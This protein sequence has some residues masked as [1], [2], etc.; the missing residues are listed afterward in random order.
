M[1]IA[2]VGAQ[3][4][5]WT[6]EQKSKAK[7]KIKEIIMNH[8]IEYDN[9]GQFEPELRPIIVSGHCPV[10][11]E[12]WYCV[13]CNGWGDLVKDTQLNPDCEYHKGMVISIYDLGGV[14]SWVEIIAARY[15]LKKEIYPAEVNQ[16]NNNSDKCPN[17][18]HV[19][20]LPRWKEVCEDNRPSRG[21][22]SR[23]IQIAEACDILYDIEPAGK[24]RY[25]NGSGSRKRYHNG[26]YGIITCK[27]CNGDGSYSGGTWTLKYAK[28]LGKIVNKIIIN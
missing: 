23:N 12:R 16:W 27:Y 6:E 8:Y 20:Y 24:C 26:G 21:Y 28:K 2:I 17:C 15:K 7:K 4:D 1:K 11:K 13:D 18:N 22:K 25:C 10:G 14:D 19:S 5:K 9:F 3:E